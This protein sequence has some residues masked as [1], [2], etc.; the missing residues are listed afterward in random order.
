MSRSD[1]VIG[2]EDFSEKQKKVFN[3][4]RGGSSKSLDGIICDGAVRSGKTLC[5]SLS[6]TLWACTNFSGCD[7]ALCGKTITSVR[8]NLVVPLMKHASD[9]GFSVKDHGA[10]NFIEIGMGGQPNRFYLFGGKDAR[11]STARRSCAYAA[12]FCGTGC[13]KVFAERFKAVVQLQSRKPL[14]LVQD[15]MDRQG[16]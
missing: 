7:F 5:M 10:K 9:W 13:G 1:G 6:F 4:W 2:W 15:R 3:W 12:Q 16:G 8:R 11:R 14:S